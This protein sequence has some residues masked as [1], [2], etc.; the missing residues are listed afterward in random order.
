MFSVD[1]YLS[2]SLVTVQDCVMVL[3][4]SCFDENTNEKMLMKLMLRCCDEMLVWI[5]AYC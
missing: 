5:H 2:S 1:T 3:S 4:M